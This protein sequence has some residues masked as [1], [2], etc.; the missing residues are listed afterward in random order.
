M[1]FSFGTAKGHPRHFGAPTDTPTPDASRAPPPPP[2][3]A[4]PAKR[5][6]EL[7]AAELQAQQL[8]QQR[9]RE[10]DRQVLLLEP[11]RKRAR[12]GHPLVRSDGRGERVRVGPLGPETCFC[13]GDG[14][15]NGEKKQGVQKWGVKTTKLRIFECLG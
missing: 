9:Q 1:C 10:A 4:P 3:R 6:L 2:R 11:S 13:M 5:S 14:P 12:P 8:L 7:L 15:E